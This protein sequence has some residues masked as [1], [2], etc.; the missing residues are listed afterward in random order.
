LPYLQPS[1]TDQ[2]DL[3][4]EGYWV[5]LKKRATYGDQLAAQSAMLKLDASNPGTISQMEWG[6]YIQALSVSMILE[7]NLT[8]E[9]D[10][11]LPITAGSLGKLSAEDGQFLAT[12]IT[13]RAKTRG[14]EQERPFA[15][16]LS[17]P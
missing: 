17:K 2:V 11:L 9:N 6:S 16:Q 4:T 15:L 10:V 3:P 7:W 12:E 14:V 1:Q 5:R 8:D 13:E